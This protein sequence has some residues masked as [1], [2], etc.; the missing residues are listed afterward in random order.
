MANWIP[1]T[2]IP[3]THTYEIPDH[4]MHILSIETC[5]RYIDTHIDAYT[6]NTDYINNNSVTSL[7]SKSAQLLKEVKGLCVIGNKDNLVVRSGTGHCQDTV[8]D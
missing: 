3:C 5:Q 4:Y 8:K 1:H 6:P 2:H 7:P